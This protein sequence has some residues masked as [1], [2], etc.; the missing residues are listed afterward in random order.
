MGG[1]RIRPDQ[2]GEPCRSQGDDANPPEDA[3]GIGLRVRALV[4][5]LARH[6]PQQDHQ[7][8]D[9]GNQYADYDQS[10]YIQ[11]HLDTFV[12]PTGKHTRCAIGI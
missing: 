12:A 1:F 3:N 4:R 8:D 2:C 10:K 9:G 6:W 11:D 7:P 5:Q